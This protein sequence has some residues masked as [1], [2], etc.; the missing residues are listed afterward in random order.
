MSKAEYFNRYYVHPL[1]P[2][3]DAQKKAGLIA[4]GIITAVLTGLFTAL[5]LMLY[6]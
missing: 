6:I 3:V 1:E 5:Y 4:A 2:Y